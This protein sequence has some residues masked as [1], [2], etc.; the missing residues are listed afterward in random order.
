VKVEIRNLV[1]GTATVCGPDLT[2][3]E[4]AGVMV[5]ERI[6]SLGVIEAGSLVGIFTDR[7][8]LR[9]VAAGTDCASAS[10]EDWMTPDPDFLTPDVDVSDAADWLMATGYRHLP[11]VEDGQLLGIV[12][13]KDVLW[14]VNEPESGGG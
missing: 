11:V 4:A 7:D 10:V 2:V 14:A 8:V 3:G 6:G 1:G 13:I 12:S 5:E 9:A